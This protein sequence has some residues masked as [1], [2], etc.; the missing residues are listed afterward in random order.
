[1]SAELEA[2]WRVDE[3]ESLLSPRP[4]FLNDTLLDV[5]SPT[6]ALLY[7]KQMD[8]SHSQI[9]IQIVDPSHFSTLIITR[10]R[11][12]SPPSPSLYMEYPPAAFLHAGTTLQTDP[13]PSPV[14]VHYLTPR[15]GVFAYF[16]PHRTPQLVAPVPSPGP[17][18]T[19]ISTGIYYSTYY[20]SLHHVWFCIYRLTP[21]ADARSDPDLENAPSTSRHCWTETVQRMTSVWTL[22]I[23]VSTVVVM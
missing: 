22:I 18:K 19:C 20:F 9:Q 12:L 4:N 7:R 5:T 23:T 15:T 1:M 21:D 14:C 11:F 8:P 13:V 3:F 2:V 16:Y 10:A 17:I 6:V